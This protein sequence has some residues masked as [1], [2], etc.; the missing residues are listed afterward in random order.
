MKPNDQPVRLDKTEKAKL[1]TD[2]VAF[3]DGKRRWIAYQTWTT[4]K[5]SIS[6]LELICGD[7]KNTSKSSLI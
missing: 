5:H 1:G 7:D 2:I 4:S 3:Y 6:E